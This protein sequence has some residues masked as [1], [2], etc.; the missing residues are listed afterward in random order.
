MSNFHVLFAYGTTPPIAFTGDSGQSFESSRGGASVNFD[1]VAAL[2]SQVDDAPVICVDDDLDYAA[3]VQANAERMGLKAVVVSNSLHIVPALIKT[4]HKARLLIT[5]LHMPNFDGLEIAQG[6]R[7]IRSPTKV[8]IVTSEP[9][10]A[11]A[12]KAKSLGFQV[13]HKPSTVADFR[14]LLAPALDGS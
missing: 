10:S 12:H 2:L 7:A 3:L 13:S 11:R 9:D 5:D 1:D 8:A 14:I 4:R 6:L